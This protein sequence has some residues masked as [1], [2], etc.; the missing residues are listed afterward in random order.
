M[1]SKD[2][3]SGFTLIESKLK[4]VNGKT[5]ILIG[6]KFNNKTKKETK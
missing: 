1:K 4:E 5:L 3:F 2:W 6:K